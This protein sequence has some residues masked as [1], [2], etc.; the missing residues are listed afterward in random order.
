MNRALIYSFI[1]IVIS[2]MLMSVIAVIVSVSIATTKAN[3]TDESSNRRWCTL[4]V[5][6]D[7]AYKSIK[8]TSPV[9]KN[10]AKQIHDLRIDFHC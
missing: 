4:L 5:T 8:P 10:I 9:G 3:N 7:E 2:S 1:I 6:L